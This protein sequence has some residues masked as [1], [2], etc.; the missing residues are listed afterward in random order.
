MLFTSIA[1]CQDQRADTIASFPGGEEKIAV[2]LKENMEWQQ[3]QLTVEGK[4]YVK[5]LVKENGDITGVVV[6]KGLCESCDKEAVRL[7]KSMPN[8]LPAKKEGV[9]IESKV[10]LPIE[11]KLYK[12]K[13]CSIC[14]SPSSDGF[15]MSMPLWF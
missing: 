9:L 13:N 5:F 7:V 14:Q 3:S 15:F 11:F 8:W 1:S 10:V 12:N 4:V 6:M 2:Y